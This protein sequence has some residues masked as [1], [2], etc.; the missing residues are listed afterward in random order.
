MSPSPADTLAGAYFPDPHS[1]N[2][3]WVRGEF[4]AVLDQWFD[5]RKGL[6]AGDPAAASAADRLSPE[7]LRKREE[8]SQHLPS[9]VRR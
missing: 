9:C 3:T 6:F 2:E 7:R 4:Q 5:W 8:L 1:E